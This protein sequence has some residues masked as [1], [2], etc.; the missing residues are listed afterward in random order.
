MTLQNCPAYSVIPREKTQHVC[1]GG[2]YLDIY[3]F[4]GAIRAIILHRDICSPM[5]TFP[6]ISKYQVLMF[7][8]TQ[9]SSIGMFSSA[10]PLSSV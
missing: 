2:N 3:L 8:E 7:V 6:N 10:L 9:V 4:E 1:G 5:Y